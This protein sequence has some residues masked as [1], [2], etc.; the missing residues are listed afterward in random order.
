[1]SESL[2]LGINLLVVATNDALKNTC[3]ADLSHVKLIHVA[4]K[5]GVG[6]TEATEDGVDLVRAAGNV[7]VGFVRVN[8]GQALLVLHRPWV[9]VLV[10]VVW[11]FHQ[12]PG[13]S[14]VNLIAIEVE[15]LHEN[16][17]VMLFWVHVPGLNLRH[18]L[19]NMHHQADG[20]ESANTTTKDL[21]DPTHYQELLDQSNKRR[22]SWVLHF[23]S[24]ECPQCWEPGIVLK[25]DVNFE[26]RSLVGELHKRHLGFSNERYGVVLC[27][28]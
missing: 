13:A 1:V 15:E 26:T 17:A 28:A 24:L 9:L 8:D 5:L 14:D 22:E 25:R 12:N 7:I 16:L 3:R 6:S 11:S 20:G 27:D 21:V 18:G 4:L 19:Q 10:V 23:P 2:T